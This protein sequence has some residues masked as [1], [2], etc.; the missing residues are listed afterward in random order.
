MRGAASTGGISGTNSGDI[1][2]SYWDTQSSAVSA[3]VG[4]G[5]PSGAGGRT[6]AELQGPTGYTGIYSNWNTD[7]DNADQ[8]FDPTTGADDFWRFGTSSQY[9]VLKWQLEGHSQPTPE[10]PGPTPA[11]TPT[12]EPPASADPCVERLETFAVTEA[13]VNIEGTWT[14]DCDS[15]NQEGSHARFYSFTLED[16]DGVRIDLTSDED[17]ILYLLRG[18]GKEGEVLEEND[19]IESGN[20]NSRITTEL[21]AGTY[22]VEATTYTSGVTGHFRLTLASVAPPAPSSHPCVTDLGERQADFSRTGDWTDECPSNNRE[23]HWA[24]FYVFSLPFQSQ[25]SITLESD[26][27]T[28]LYLM[29]GDGKDEDILAENDDLETGNTN[30]NIT[31]TLAARVYTVEATTYSAGET[32]NF[33]L[34]VSGLGTAAPAQSCGVGLTLAAGERCSHHDFTIEVDGSGTLLMR[35]TGDSVDFDNLSLVRSDDSWTIEELPPPVAQPPDS[36]AGVGSWYTSPATSEVVL[37]TA[38]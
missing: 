19:D 29:E 35:F 8:D 30:S 11:P 18:Y 5:D 25:V 4:E 1:T 3:A 6:T 37:E 14:G 13:V 16:T 12:P 23:G 17:T 28:Y 20:T 22:T 15:V 27:D 26:V 2:W 9:P 10:P 7:L 24:Y 21:E 34:T 36:S 31:E 38:S 32:G 33:T